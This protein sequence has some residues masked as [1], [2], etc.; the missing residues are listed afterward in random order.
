M[1]PTYPPKSPDVQSERRLSTPS[2]DYMMGQLVGRLEALSANIDR[3]H[4]E[5]AKLRTDFVR[6]HEFD[7][8]RTETKERL[9]AYSGRL[10]PLEHADWSRKWIDKAA[11]VGLSAAVAGLTAL[12]LGGLPL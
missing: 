3:L 5:I 10:G 1:T 9:A 8:F 7:E 4:D 2:T 12:A 11:N 6:K